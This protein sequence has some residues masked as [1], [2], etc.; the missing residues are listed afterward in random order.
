MPGS[1]SVEV[2]HNQEAL[3]GKTSRDLP[4]AD[5]AQKMGTHISCQ[6]NCFPLKSCRLLDILRNYS[7][8]RSIAVAVTRNIASS[9]V[10]ICS[11]VLLLPGQ[12]DE[13]W[14]PSKNQSSL[15]YLGA[16]DRT[17]L[18]NLFVFNDLTFAHLYGR[19]CGLI[20][21]GQICVRNLGGGGGGF[22]WDFFL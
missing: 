16:L 1:S 10:C 6:L 22:E 18:A 20:E 21:T 17:V 15:V 12:T 7:S 9:A 3:Y 2:G 11:Y 8:A 14:E 19:K 13:A 4:L 5:I